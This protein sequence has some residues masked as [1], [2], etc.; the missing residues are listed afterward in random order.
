MT[1]LRVVNVTHT[2]VTVAWMEPDNP[3]GKTK[4]YIVNL[5]KNAE[6]I[7]SISRN[8]TEMMYEVGHSVQ[9]LVVIMCVCVCTDFFCTVHVL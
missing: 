2:S 4:N 5:V 3:R 8:I 7:I 1:D 6:E 9:S